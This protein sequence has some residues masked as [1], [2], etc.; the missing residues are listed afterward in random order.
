MRLGQI[1]N[2][3]R[4][5]DLPPIKLT[6]LRNHPV[7]QEWLHDAPDHDARFMLMIG[8]GDFVDIMSTALF[9]DIVLIFFVEYELGTYCDIDLGGAQLYWDSKLNDWVQF[10]EIEDDAA[11]AKKGMN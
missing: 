6:K 5:C 4:A 7:L 2:D 1:V 8:Q 11:E 3:V 9:T 10:S